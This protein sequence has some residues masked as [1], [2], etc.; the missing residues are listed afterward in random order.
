[1]RKI[2]S[3]YLFFIISLI[4]CTPTGPKLEPLDLLSEGLALKIL[5]PPGVKINSSDLGIMKDVTVKND[6]GYSIQIFETSATK[7]NV[8]SIIEEKKA[9]VK[10]S[11]FF[12]Q[13]ISEEEDGFIFEKKIDENYI[14][15]DFRHVRIRGDKQY[16]IQSGLS[17]KNTLEQV[18][19]M[20]KSVQ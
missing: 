17:S 3:Y 8:L 9:E 10:S 19:L 13:I 5:V 15:Y 12:S 20:F 7:L 16:L 2:L 1:M 6:D 18:Q 4:A 11:Q 14:N